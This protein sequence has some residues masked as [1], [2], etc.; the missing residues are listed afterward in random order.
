MCQAWLEHIQKSLA[1]LSINKDRPDGKMAFDG[2]W[3]WIGPEMLHLMVLPNPD[4]MTGRPDN[5][6]RDRHVCVGVESIKPIE[7]RLKAKGVQYTS[8]RSGR[9]AIFFRDPDMNVLEMFESKPW[10]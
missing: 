4:P 6:G 7:Q 10:R 2:L 3:L 1:G 8:S 9:P 5:G